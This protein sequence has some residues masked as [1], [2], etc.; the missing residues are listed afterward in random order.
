MAR[1][2]VLVIVI[3]VVAI[4]ACGGAAETASTLDAPAASTT[5]APTTTTTSESPT[6]T[7]TST[8]TTSTTTEPPTTT[9]TAAPAIEAAVVWDG[10]DCRYEG[11]E[12]AAVG[13]VVNVVFRNEGDIVADLEIDY[14]ARGVTLEEGIAAWPSE[15]RSGDDV[16]EGTYSLAFIP[17]WPDSVDPGSEASAQ[18]ELVIARPHVFICWQGGANAVVQSIGVAPTGLTATD[19]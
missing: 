18:V 2:S 5:A 9:T 7:T 4:A 14:L 8:T 12:T 6:S 10:A 15:A 17:E 19:G 16:P 3:A 11:P 13:S 1:S